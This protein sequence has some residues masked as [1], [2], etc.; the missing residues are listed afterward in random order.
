MLSRA[1]NREGSGYETKDAGTA[2]CSQPLG[3][4]GALE[5]VL[6]WPKIR[7]H[8]T[9]QELVS[10]YKITRITAHGLFD[11]ASAT[12]F[13]GAIVPWFDTRLQRVR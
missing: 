10:H 8:T 1:L 13:P 3:A 11:T 6:P 7:R 2:G 5:L 4:I 12:V 9:F